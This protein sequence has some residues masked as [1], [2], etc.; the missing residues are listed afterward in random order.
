MA[1]SISSNDNI[2]TGRAFAQSFTW[3]KIIPAFPDQPLPPPRVHHGM[4]YFSR[5]PVIIIFGGNGEGGTLNDTWAFDLSDNTW[6]EVR[7]Y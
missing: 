3:Q 6:K 7:I 5:I 4:G 2:V 1:V